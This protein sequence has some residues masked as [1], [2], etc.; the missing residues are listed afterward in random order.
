MNRKD[1]FAKIGRQEGR[2]T[3]NLLL[4]CGGITVDAVLA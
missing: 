3:G 1:K 4:P 2:K